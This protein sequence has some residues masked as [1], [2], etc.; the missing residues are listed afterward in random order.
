MIEEKELVEFFEKMLNKLGFEIEFD[1]SL[2][3]QLK[4]AEDLLEQ[5]EQDISRARA[6]IIAYCA[7][8]W[9]RAHQPYLDWVVKRMPHLAITWDA[10][11]L[12]TDWEEL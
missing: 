1:V 11:Y 4:G 3:R 6:V 10:S 12:A 8:P 7:D 9:W 2:K 5:C